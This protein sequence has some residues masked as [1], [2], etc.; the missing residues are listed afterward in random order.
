MPEPVAGH[1][2]V[3][4]HSH[5]HFPFVFLLFEENVGDLVTHLFIPNDNELPGLAVAS[6]RSPAG[7]I[8]NLS[9]HLIGNVFPSIVST[10]TS[11]V[12]GQFAKFVD[13]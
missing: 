11:S 7:A 1:F 8:K 10:D 3:S 4:P 6:R 13:I 2:G 9:H 12:G 5:L